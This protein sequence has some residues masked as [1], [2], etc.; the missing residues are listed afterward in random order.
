MN[1]WHCS[2]TVEAFSNRS[3]RGSLR[4]FSRSVLSSPESPQFAKL[5][6]QSLLNNVKSSGLKVAELLTP[7]LKESKFHETGVLTPEEF[8]AA[9]DHLVHQVGPIPLRAAFCSVRSFDDQRVP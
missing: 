8:V 1:I 4:R 3:R 6:M 9:G 5:N 7:V 2:C